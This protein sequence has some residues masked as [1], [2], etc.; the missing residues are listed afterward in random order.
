MKVLRNIAT[1]ALL[2]LAIGAQ[3]KYKM[4]TTYMYGFAASFN[5]STVYFTDIQEVDSVWLETK[6]KF[7]YGRDNYSY[8]LK[9]H[10]KGIGQEHP[11]CLVVFAEK[12]KDAEKKYV[13]MRKRYVSNKKGQHLYNIKYINANDFRFKGI[14]PDTDYLNAQNKTK[15]SKKK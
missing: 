13:K 11:A 1:A 6:N 10:L 15:K 3:A 4:N 9:D 7:L 12:K 8:Q 5:D 14:L 2:S